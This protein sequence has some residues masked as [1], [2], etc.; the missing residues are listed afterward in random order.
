MIRKIL[1]QLIVLISININA[2][3]EVEIYLNAGIRATQLQN[4]NLALKE[5]SKVIKLDSLNERAYLN[6]AITYNKLPSYT[7]DTNYKIGLNGRFY[8]NETDTE[9]LIKHLDDSLY[10]ITKNGRERKAELVLKDYLRMNSYKIMIVR[11]EKGN[12]KGLNV[13]NGR[14]KNVIFEKK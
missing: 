14:I 3:E 6:R 2:Q 8:N 12:V 4:Y 10:S 7:L 9:I 11:D 5:F 13:K 1:I